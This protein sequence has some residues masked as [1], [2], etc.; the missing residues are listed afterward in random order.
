MSNFS[1]QLQ[2]VQNAREDFEWYPTTN[3]ILDCLI[4]D[5]T[6]FEERYPKN[7][8]FLDIGAG[9]G[10][11]IEKVKKNSIFEEFFAIEKSRQLIEYLPD[12]VYILGV[13]FHRTTL[14]EK[15]IKVIFCN[16]PYSEYEEWACKILKE[17]WGQSNVYLVIP[18]RW[19]ES[20]KIK[21]VLAN[22]NIH[23]EILGE[24]DFLSAEDRS[25]RA[26][27]EL[28]SFSYLKG[29]Y[30]DDP[31]CDFFD[32]S[33]QFPEKK[34]DQ[35]EIEE[36]LEGQIVRGENFVERLVALYD[37]RISQL[38]KNYSAICSLDREILDEFDINKRGLI[39][40][41]RSKLENT[42]KIF[43]GKLFDGMEEITKKLTTNSRKVILNKLNSQ[44]GI[45]FNRD[46]IYAVVIWTIKNANKYF[47]SQFIEIYEKMISFTNVTNYKSNQR[48]FTTHDFRYDHYQKKE[49][50][51]EKFYLKIGHRIVLDSYYMGLRVNYLGKIEASDSA[52]NFIQ[53][54][55]TIANNLGFFNHTSH[56]RP[57]DFN[58][59]AVRY[60]EYVSEKGAESLFEV[61][62]FRN[63]NMHLRFNPDFLH[64]MNI[65]HGKLKGW[66]KSDYEAQ[67]EISAPEELSKKTFF[68]DNR[69][70]LNKVKL[71]S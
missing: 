53:D 16:P 32:E 34:E 63:G 36:E 64:A 26:K 23:F 66:L 19:K 8:S 29:E 9:N 44:T 51:A 47:D 52:F 46:N 55:K 45:E 27:V 39:K 50:K 58:S 35:E 62:L 37:L 12:Y 60:Y 67:E 13:D 70:T 7:F 54:L 21:D 11:V 43:W 24:F 31:F 59:N 68:L 25:A 10:K 4:K 56:E 30:G 15:E 57:E 2:S 48:V 17:S 38:Q 40:S 61:R 71:L 3:E 65:M 49:I 41:L 42:K 18:Q 6:K 14:L 5:L 33:F 1:S 28:I 22:R 69:I 20:K